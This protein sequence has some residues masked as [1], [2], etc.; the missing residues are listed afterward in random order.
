MRRRKP[1][2]VKRDGRF[3]AGLL[4]RLGD[5][6]GKTTTPIFLPLLARTSF[7]G[8]SIRIE[9]DDL[10]D[11]VSQS[12]FVGFLEAS[13][14]TVLAG[15][16]LTSAHEVVKGLSPPG[17]PELQFLR[18]CRNASA[19]G[20]RFHL[21]PGEPKQPASWRSF[22]VDPSWHDRPLTA[23]VV[24]GVLEPGDPLLLLWDIE[25][26]LRAADLVK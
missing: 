8:P 23:N 18:H 3:P 19:H 22:K 12:P 25:Q 10:A 1:S 20:W 13:S 7:G 26:Q 21:K 6:V 16:L 15:Q 14:P 17:S 9:S 2:N 11:E 24:N 4:T 5:L